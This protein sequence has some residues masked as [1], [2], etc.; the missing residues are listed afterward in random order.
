MQSRKMLIRVISLILLLSLT[1]PLL[2]QENGTIKAVTAKQTK[3]TKAKKK[4]KT[5]LRKVKSELSKKSIYTKASLQK[6]NKKYKKVSK[7]KEKTVKQINKKTKQLKNVLKI[8]KKIPNTDRDI[9]TP[10]PAT[11]TNVPTNSPSPVPTNPTPSKEVIEQQIKYFICGFI[12]SDM[13]EEEYQYHIDALPKNYENWEE[14]SDI[15][16]DVR[17]GK[18]SVEELDAFVKK[19]YPVDFTLLD[20]F[21]EGLSQED[22]STIFE[23]WS[24]EGLVRNIYDFTVTQSELEWRFQHEVLP[25]AEIIKKST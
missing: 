24:L 13:S 21:M 23:W 5:Q 20:E 8:L 22:F 15:V 4:L 9:Q 6:A 16:K 7:M 3:T 25:Y 1:A 2:L 19:P 11:P 12:F 14:I 10:E 18:R 17:D